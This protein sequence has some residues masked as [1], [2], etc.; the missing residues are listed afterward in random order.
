[1]GKKKKKVSKNTKKDK[2]KIVDKIQK[3]ED[4]KN[5]KILAIVKSEFNSPLAEPIADA[6]RINKTLLERDEQRL[7]EWQE[8]YYM[9]LF[10]KF[11]KLIIEHNEAMNFKAD[12]LSTDVN[13]LT[14]RKKTLEKQVKALEHRVETLKSEKGILEDA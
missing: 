2:Q 4:K 11:K 13:H 6:V 9:S 10:L 8:E 14:K 3:Q 5:K 7:K 12:E 1:M